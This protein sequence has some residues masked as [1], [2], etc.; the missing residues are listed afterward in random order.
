MQRCPRCTLVFA[1]GME[2]CPKCG[3]AAGVIRD[4]ATVEQRIVHDP[5]SFSDDEQGMVWRATMTVGC[6]AVIAGVVS[7]FFW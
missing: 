3:A 2:S 5:E 1:P 6:V 7:I 4:I